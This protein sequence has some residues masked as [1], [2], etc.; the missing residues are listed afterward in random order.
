[1]A[2]VKLY[3]GVPGTQIASS[4]YTVSTSCADPDPAAPDN[5]ADG[6]LSTKFTCNDAGSIELLFSFLSSPSPS[7]YDI[8]TSADLPNAD[9]KSWTFECRL[10]APSSRRRHLSYT[11]WQ[12]L[13]TVTDSP[14]VEA[15][16]A[17]VGPFAVPT[18][19]STG[20]IYKSNGILSSSCPSGTV[21][22]SQA[23]CDVI[24]RN[25]MPGKAT[26]THYLELQSLGQAL[27]RDSVFGAAGL[28]QTTATVVTEAN[29]ATLPAGCYMPVPTATDDPDNGKIYYNMNGAGAELPES[30]AKICC[31]GACSAL[32]AY[33]DPHLTF[34]HGGYAHFRGVNHGVF[35][36]LSAPNVTFNIET[37]DALYNTAFS[38]RKVNGSFMIEATWVIRTKANHTV[39]VRYSAKVPDRAIVWQG[40]VG[41]GKFTVAAKGWLPAY[42][43]D[44]KTGVYSHGESKREKTGRGAVYH[45]LTEDRIFKLDDVTVAMPK[46]KKLLVETEGWAFQAKQHIWYPHHLHPRLSISMR[47]K[48]DVESPSG[49]A[50]HGL[51]GQSWDRDQ[52]AITGA[53]D[54][55][56]SVPK[57][58]TFTTT[59]QAE[60]AIEGRYTD[61]LLSNPF[62]TSFRYSRFDAVAPM[63]PRN[64]SALSG[65]RSPRATK[66][67]VARAVSV[68][69]SASVAH[70]REFAMAK[71]YWKQRGKSVGAKRY[72]RKSAS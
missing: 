65:S 41:L 3:T 55:Y 16:G 25:I 31:V 23:E 60:G 46:T 43:P 57:G 6:D 52:L 51:I 12:I 50:P 2:E 64:V 10:D 30:A 21:A 37:E 33:G 18:E 61:Y 39:F 34:A 47:P 11:T 62:A 14:Q 22:P 26:T 66:G 27:L 20:T 58:A 71:G 69:R 5:V 19:F 59:A 9:P 13:S 24:A 40:A 38:G 28:A 67:D 4:T 36:F 1:M 72:G 53:I 32:D 15:R 54:N 70:G 17:S 63:P 35:N 8:I 68:P 49:V 48:Y 44:E 42:P 7:S 45:I 56:Y 29:G